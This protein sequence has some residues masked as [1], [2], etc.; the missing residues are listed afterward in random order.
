MM[1]SDSVEASQPEI[2]T[3]PGARISQVVLTKI[4]IPI[5]ASA[6]ASAVSGVSS[7]GFHTTVSPHTSATAEFHAQTAVECALQLH[8]HV[9]DRIGDIAKQLQVRALHHSV[10]GDVGDDVPRTAF[11]IKA[12]QHL[13]QIATVGLPAAAAQ[14]PA[15]VLEL[16]IQADGH[17]IAV[18]GDGAR[19]ILSVKATGD[20]IAI[21]NALGTGDHRAE[22]PPSSA[23]WAPP[24]PTPPRCAPW[25]NRCAA[26]R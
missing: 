10:F 12:F 3:C 22:P 1:A 16:H 21:E 17:A 25:A 23:A 18:F 14:P 9:K 20:R 26:S 5:Q 19:L 8:P 4:E 13:P 11:A 24:P 7:E 2:A 15:A 6:A